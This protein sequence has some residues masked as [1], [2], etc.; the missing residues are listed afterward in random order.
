MNGKL[1]LQNLNKK[2]ILLLELQKNGIF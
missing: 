1:T 2:E